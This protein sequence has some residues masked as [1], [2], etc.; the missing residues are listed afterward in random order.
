MCILKLFQ[1]LYPSLGM[2]YEQLG[3]C[4]LH[5]PSISSVRKHMSSDPPQLRLEYLWL[6]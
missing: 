4:N 3:L 6:K 2:E 1:T 5:K